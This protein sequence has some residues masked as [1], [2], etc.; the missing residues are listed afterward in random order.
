MKPALIVT[1]KPNLINRKFGGPEFDTSTDTVYTLLLI[2]RY[3]A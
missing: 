2:N 1:A 3:T